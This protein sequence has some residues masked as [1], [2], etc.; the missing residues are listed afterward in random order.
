MDFFEGGGGLF[1]YLFQFRSI[2]IMNLFFLS[3]FDIFSVMIQKCFRRSRS[4]FIEKTAF[5]KLRLVITLNKTLMKHTQNNQKSIGKSIPAYGFL[6][7]QEKNPANRKSRD[8]CQM[9]VIS[10]KKTI[11]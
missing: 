1:V 10:K 2:F 7:S 6:K 9:F 5:V 11:P 3:I 8:F 4:S